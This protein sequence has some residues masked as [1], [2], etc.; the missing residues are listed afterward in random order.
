[1]YVCYCGVS[2]PSLP[3][4]VLITKGN[5]QAMWHIWR[6]PSTV[7]DP[8]PGS[9]AMIKTCHVLY[10]LEACLHRTTMD[11]TATWQDMLLQVAD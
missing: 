7:V 2:Y 5:E 4:N 8:E 6:L 3:P 11:I 10:K 9:E 1:M